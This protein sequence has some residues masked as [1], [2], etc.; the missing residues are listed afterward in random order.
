MTRTIAIVEDEKDQLENYS[1]ALE[2]AGYRVH[3]YSSKDEAS[4][5]FARALPDMVILDI[6]LGKEQDGGFDLCR[7]LLQK[8]PGLPIIFLTDRIDEI[9]RISGLRMGAWDY[10]TKPISL[11]VLT[12]KVATLFRILE[13]RNSET[14]R[15]GHE[16]I[17]ETNELH[18]NEDRMEVTWKGKPVDLT[19]TEFRILV[20]IVKY[21]G[22]VKSYDELMDS[23]MQSVVTRNTIATHVKK[24]RRKFGV[25]DTDFDFIESVHGLGYKWRSEQ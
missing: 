24:I 8:K 10:E 15:A 14:T 7:M 11:R 9:D 25:V 22:R 3:K 18:M 1:D 6:I 2:R 13:F 4:E 17:I 23:A 16:R 20:D 12:E 19:N 5:A 21:P